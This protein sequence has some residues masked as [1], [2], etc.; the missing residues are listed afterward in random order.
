MSL[1]LRVQV[2][3][4]ILERERVI[5]S[6]IPLSDLPEGTYNV[7]VPNFIL[8]SQLDAESD[9]TRGQV[10]EFLERKLL[11]CGLKEI[12]AYVAVVPDESYV[13]NIIN[14]VKK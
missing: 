5:I 1:D 4:N 8:P 3:R 6:T 2:V 11:M 13:L 14:G 9:L 12:T 7:A 10:C